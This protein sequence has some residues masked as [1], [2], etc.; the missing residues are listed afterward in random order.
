M[1]TN[2]R[3]KRP[4]ASR[5]QNSPKKPA[6]NAKVLDRLGSDELAAVL[7]TL[8]K[9]H[10]DLRT[11]AEK[12]AVDLVSSPSVEDIAGEILFNVTNLDMDD[13]NGRAGK[14]SW[15]YVEPTEAAWDAR[16]WAEMDATTDSAGIESSRGSLPPDAPAASSGLHPEGNAS[17]IAAARARASG[18]WLAG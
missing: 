4:N 14:H 16:G 18:R 9:S 12:I 7:R 13:L 15:G 2:K 8:L 11:E 5:P 3:S 1:A 17:R 10:P 6:A